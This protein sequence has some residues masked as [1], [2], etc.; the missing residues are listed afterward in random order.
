MLIQNVVSGPSDAQGN[1]D[2]QFSAEDIECEE[3]DE[4]EEPPNNSRR[5]RTNC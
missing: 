4:D 2:D 1:D 3:G 5:T